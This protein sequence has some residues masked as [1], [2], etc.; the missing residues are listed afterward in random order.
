MYV[1]DLEQKNRGDGI[2]ITDY[3]WEFWRLELLP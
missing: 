1:I 2:N 3:F